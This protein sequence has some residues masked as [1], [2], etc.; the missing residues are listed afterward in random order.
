MKKSVLILSS[1]YLF[2]VGMIYYFNEL[3]TQSKVEN[4]LDKHL[5]NLRT[6]YDIF[7][8]NQT[9]LANFFYNETISNAQAMEILT[10]ANQTKDSEQLAKLREKLTRNLSTQYQNYQM[11]SITKY[12]FIF[13]DNKLF[14]RMDKIEQFGDDLSEIRKDYV[15]VNETKEVLRGFSQGKHLHAFRN[16]YPLFDKDKNHIG[17]VEISFPSALLQDYL[18]DVSKIHSHFLVDTNIFDKKVLKKDELLLN[19][20][21]SQENPEYMITIEKRHMSDECTQNNDAR[22]QPLLP[23]IKR[24]MQNNEPFVLAS[25]SENKSMAISFY[26][27][28]EYGNTKALAWIVAYED[29]KLLG[30]ILKNKSII[31]IVFMSI[32]LLLFFFIYRTINQK[33]LFMEL[34]NRFELA[35]DGVNDG[36][37]DWDIK[38]NKTY[39]SPRWKMMLGYAKDDISNT[40]E[41]FFELIHEDDKERTKK[42]LENHFKD[43][44]IPYSVELRMRCKDGSY[45]WILA[46][47]KASLDKDANPIRM[48]GSHT[49]IDETKNF[50]DKIKKAEFKFFTLF[51]E[52]LDAIVLVDLNTQ[53]FI[54]YNQKAYEFYGYTK[55][56]FSDVTVRDLEALENNEEIQKRQQNI[57]QRG[58]DHFFTKHKTKD[59]SLKDVSVNVIK[60]VLDEKPLLYAT[61]HD[62]TKE[63]ELQNSIFKEKNFISA[64]LENANLIVAVIDVKGTMIKLNRYGQ[65][66]TGYSEEEISSQPYFWKCL[67]QEQVKD[68]IED[69]MQNATKGIIKKS[70]QSAWIS[71]NGE[72]RMFEWSNTLV[73]KE[74]GTM[75]YLATI[76]ID[77]TE[78]INIQKQIELQKDEFETIFKTTKDGLAI[79]DLESNFLEFNDAYLEMTGFTRE[80]LLTKSC[81]GLSVPEDLPR[82]LVAIKE[83]IDKGFITNFEKSCI[84]KNE[85]IVTINMSIAHMPDK[86]RFLISTKDIT[87]NKKIQRDLVE[88][89]ESAEKA[90]KAKSE[91]LANMSHE[92][93]TPLNGVLG[94]TDL[95]LKTNLDAQQRD[96]LE[97]A[98][99]SSKALL[100]IINDVLD[101]SKIDAGKLDLE[102]KEFELSSVMCNIKDLFEYQANKK[103]ISLTISGD[104]N[105]T[106]IG[107]ALRLTQI[108]TN[109][110]GNAIK[111]TEKGSIDIKVELIYENEHHKKLKFSIKDSGMGMNKEHQEN[112]FKKFTQAD[113]S[114]TRKYGGTGLG[115]SISKHLVQMMSGEI[116][117]ESQEGVGSTFIF[118]ATFEKN[119]DNKEVVAKPQINASN[120]DSIQGARIL[121]AE[122]NKINQTVAMGML[123]NL[124]L[125]VDLANNGREAV[126]MIEAGNK[127]DI[128]L[129]D[130]Q[131]PIMDGFEASKRIKK[132]DKN[133]P[134]IALS[135][136]VMQ[137]DI[138]KTSEAEMSAHLAKP[139]NEEEL[140]RTLLQF[141]QLKKPDDALMQENIKEAVKELPHAEPQV[142][143]YGVDL[144]ELKHRIGDKPKIVQKILLSFCEEYT[145]A[146]EIFDMSKIETDEF[147]KAMHSLKGVSGNISL[148]EIYKL[149][150]E[151]YET[152]DLQLKKELTPKLVALLKET[153]ENLKIQ[154]NV[155][156]SKVSEKEYNKE[157][158][159]KYLQE[160]Q[161]DIKH[162]RVLNGN[163][164]VLIEEMLSRHV[165]IKTI[166]EFSSYLQGYKYKEADK[167][168]N[169]IYK[170]LGQ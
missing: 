34:K 127:Y 105:R 134:I 10:K 150:K 49:D 102:H 27:I 124:N 165:E 91:F 50:T 7:F 37:W 69:I 147:D 141:I 152:Q 111:F 106:L 29:D 16:I 17:A 33:N 153:V 169:D 87:Q 146:Q 42:L 54:E 74:D 144:E 63:K 157:E 22:I 131:M 24:M 154:L 55:E 163:K 114:I 35:L 83:V 61:F 129:M 162:F 95:V 60:I 65:E 120:T 137:E 130:L 38:N 148:N 136:A 96:Y 122:D 160:I 44:S 156:Q 161:D 1:L 39:F 45:K 166:K 133:I 107:D 15:R 103:G 9:N 25:H 68:K 12:S 110:V 90:N 88:A 66:F 116:W 13:P 79:L 85:K 4:V 98:K 70:Y 59:G 72:E 170:L 43:P 119:D 159:L 26:P 108:L 52:S 31:N 99:T 64:I 145:D 56:E 138:L 100:H 93:R 135:A 21:P 121:L 76:G 167:T 89:K 58:W 28:K 84:I 57:L 143:F 36:I 6:Y 118:S 123:E 132:I 53:K 3:N 113:N 8:Y 78:K 41:A 94:L 5:S 32:L 40:S 47:G 125:Y 30:Q 126:E 73:N 67:L 20:K 18:T 158:I 46:R 168:L 77:I 97:K 109:I 139:I 81:L 164:I 115:L 62:M 86:Q 75:D 51:Q 19:Y 71:R 112:L 80:E 101:Y 117:V 82:A 140:I 14:L 151:I 2:L 128:I 11:H 149:S 155:T 104:N 23:K 48:V 92:I 142:E